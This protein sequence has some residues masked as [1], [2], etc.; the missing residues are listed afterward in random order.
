MCL[1]EVASETSGPLL[2]GSA[3]AGKGRVAKT[4]SIV[5]VA[6]V[7]AGGSSVAAEGFIA[8]GATP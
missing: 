6:F 5:L 2:V 8:S 1:V 3:L 7:S 4:I